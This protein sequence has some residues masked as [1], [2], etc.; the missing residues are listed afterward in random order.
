MRPTVVLFTIALVLGP[1]LAAL[2]AKDVGPWFAKWSY[3][4]VSTQARH[5]AKPDYLPG[6]SM[7]S[8]RCGETGPAFA[9]VWAI[10]RYDRKHG[11]ALAK[12]STDQCS[13][14]VFKAPPPPGVSLPAAD[15]S[16][17]GTGRGIHIGSS[18]ESVVSAY[19]G[20]AVKRGSHMVFSYEADIPGHTVSLPAKAITLP[21]TITFVVDGGR[22]SAINVSIDE[23]GEF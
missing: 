21:E 10:V 8:M 6:T 4:D 20:A 14:A 18:Y 23:S 2:A 1:P 19:G 9:G 13:V 5:L 22:V 11:I 3:A 7:R 17:Y 16:R 12:S 15:L